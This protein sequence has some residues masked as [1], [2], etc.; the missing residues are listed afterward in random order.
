MHDAE[1]GQDSHDFI[2][3]RAARWPSP[4]PR[5]FIPAGTDIM[6][7]VMSKRSGRPPHDP[8]FAVQVHRT[9]SSLTA[10]DAVATALLGIQ[11]QLTCINIRLD[12][13]DGRL[14]RMDDRFDK[15]DERFNRMDDRFD[16]MDDRFDKMDI[17][18]DELKAEVRVLTMWKERVFGVVAT[19]TVL[20]ALLAFVVDNVLKWIGLRSP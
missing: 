15:M 16:K 11:A 12:T 14:D 5:S 17:R 3:R 18:F 10:G 6:E 1:T 4:W 2:R 8:G 13:I 9:P 20:F 7:Q 19:C